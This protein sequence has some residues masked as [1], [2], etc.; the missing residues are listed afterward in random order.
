MTAAV[1]VKQVA[2]KAEEERTRNSRRSDP[3]ILRELSAKS[4]E[5]GD[6]ASPA[7]FPGFRCTQKI[8][9][10]CHDDDDDGDRPVVEVVVAVSATAATKK[11]MRRGGA[12]LL[13]VFAFIA[14]SN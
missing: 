2:T 3:S 13:S 12:K 10:R 6:V 5:T 1:C 7:F 8:A 14:S 11:R 4:F 9:G